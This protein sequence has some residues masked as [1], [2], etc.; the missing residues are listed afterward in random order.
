MVNDNDVVEVWF[1]APV[2][3]GWLLVGG[4]DEI[5]RLFS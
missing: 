1:D 5:N 2:H 4:R 3:P